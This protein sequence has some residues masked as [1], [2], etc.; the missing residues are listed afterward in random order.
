MA[1]GS[2]GREGCVELS[3]G[4][5]GRPAREWGQGVAGIVFCIPRHPEVVPSQGLVH[6]KCSEDACWRD[7]EF[8]P[9]A[10][11]PPGSHTRL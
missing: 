1:K 5:L 6:G 7:H 9:P 3:W 8:K 4:Y 2:E 10:T 11:W